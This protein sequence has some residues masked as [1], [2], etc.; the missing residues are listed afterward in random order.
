[1]GRHT[2]EQAAELRG[3]APLV[4]L[5]AGGPQLVGPCTLVTNGAKTVAFSSAELLRNAGE[6]LA[7]ALTLDGKRTI[8]VASWSLA[9]ASG[10]G[11]VELA[12]PFPKGGA[13]DVSPINVGAVCATVDTRGAPSALVT[14]TADRGFSRRIVPVHVDAWDG[15]GM[16][17][18]VIRVASPQ[19]A[20][21]LDAVVEGAPVYSW[22]PP[23]PVLGRPSEVVAV[24]LAVPYR[25]K[26]VK[27]RDL[28]PLAELVGLED[29]GR[30]LPF[31]VAEEEG[32]DLR[33]VAG[34]IKDE[35]EFTGPVSMPDLPDLED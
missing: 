9:R 16:S 10:L 30:A 13:L 31:Q 22:L 18:V 25:A 4:V 8:R 29:L 7:I 19:D 26:H 1:M 32:N 28:P 35:D 27:M 12:E 3:V 33:Q 14:I 20:A 11:I 2:R 6:P 24:A 34:E 17:D 23:D 15:N 21:D 5:A